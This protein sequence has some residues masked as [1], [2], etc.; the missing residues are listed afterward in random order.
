M[1]E[2]TLA[3]LPSWKT[4]ASG[5]VRIT[6]TTGDLPDGV[7]PEF[8]LCNWFFFRFCFSI[9]FCLVIKFMP[10]LAAEDTIAAAKVAAA[11]AHDLILFLASEQWLVA[12]PGTRVFARPHLS[13]SHKLYHP[14][15][16]L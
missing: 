4:S 3:E 2:A 8:V 11:W 1:M 15:P 9:A 5:A 16:L 12:G 7:L 13:E 14:S 6:P 10:T